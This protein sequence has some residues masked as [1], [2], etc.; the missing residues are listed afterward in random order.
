MKTR[1]SKLA[2]S[3]LVYTLL[4][5]A[6]PVVFLWA[7]NRGTDVPATAVLNALALMLAGTLLLFA[8]FF[9]VFR[10]P[11]RA[12]IATTIVVVLFATFG[13]VEDFLGVGG[14]T[15][16]ESSLLVAWGLFCLV[17]ILLA[18]GVQR[19]E[20][21]TRPLNL[22]ATVLVVMNLVPVFPAL[23]R[24]TVDATARWNVDPAT[25]DAHASGP[26]RD[27][28][29][30][31]FDRYAGDQTL[32]SIYG[33]DNTS[34]LDSLRAKGFHVVDN[35]LADY[36]QTT[37]SLASSLNMT[38]LDDLAQD[39][40]TD[41]GHWNPLYASF[42]DPTVA[43]AF[44]SM[45][46]QYEHVGSWWEVTRDD[47]TADRNFIFGGP[48]EFG[49]VFM[50]T[51]IL[52]ALSRRLGILPG[53]FERQE[54]E[55]LPYQV[56]SLHT[57]A[58]DPNPTFTFAHFLFPHPPYVFHADGSFAPPGEDRSVEQAYMEQLQYA[59]TVIGSIVDM[60]QSQPGPKPV[61]VVQSDE[62]P[63]P[64]QLDTDLEIV[65]YDWASA[66][67]VE[68]GRHL[69]IL[70]ALYLPG[71]KPDVEI[72]PDLTPVNT[73]RIVLDDYFGAKLPLLP[74][75]TYVFHGSDHPYQFIDV[76]D[77]LRN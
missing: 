59:N 47:P 34:F 65:H 56:D 19:P 26:A 43:R 13:H 32:S 6:Y 53:N 35:A 44:R 24:S 64:P 39:V 8:L 28:Y 67:D 41:S 50:D 70:N 36:P 37:H 77:R 54:W 48:P 23:A 5:A 14:G 29:Y 63:Y 2:S 45:G 49:R 73:F 42:V 33:Y 52:P 20:R 21:A 74:N 31:I 62:G 75:R 51:T 1:L 7:H 4:F 71:L 76:T 9:L 72:A 57:I 12:A 22:I 69:R 18:R 30:L 25:L 27:V 66:D 58:Q 68:L 11:S 15:L 40:G 10:Q 3:P 55:R 46:Y 61:I 38:Y 16:E 17:A 60:L